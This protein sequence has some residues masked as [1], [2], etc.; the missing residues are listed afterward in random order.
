[1]RLWDLRMT[2]RAVSELRGHDDAVTAMCLVPGSGPG[3]GA[4]A[5]QGGLGSTKAGGSCGQVCLVTASQDWTARVWR[6]DGSAA[7]SRERRGAEA[8]VAAS[9]E[10]RA[11]AGQGGPGSRRS[12]GGGGSGGGTDVDV[13]R[14]QAV[15]VGHGAPVSSV[16]LLPGAVAAAW[17]LRAGRSF[18]SPAGTGAGSGHTCVDGVNGSCSGGAHGS[19]GGGG[20]GSDDGDGVFVLT[21]ASDGGLGVWDLAGRCRGLWQLSQQAPLLGLGVTSAWDRQDTLLTGKRSGQGATAGGVAVGVGRYGAG[22]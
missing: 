17:G 5:V 20:G 13:W 1:M 16:Q 2:Q 3:V 10:A 19:T 21:G 18:A 22:R 15:M 7:F 11:G 4:G 14:S 8:G 9:A 6:L 12:S